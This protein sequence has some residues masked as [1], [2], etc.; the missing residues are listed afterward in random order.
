M[1]FSITAY[2]GAAYAGAL[3]GAVI[4]IL[5][6]ALARFIIFPLWPRFNFLARQGISLGYHLLN[7]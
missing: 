5:R 3:L 7:T 2:A 6:R 4:S 1:E